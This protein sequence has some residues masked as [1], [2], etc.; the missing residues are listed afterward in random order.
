MASGPVLYG[1]L[2]MS[3]NAL[4]NNGSTTAG[5]EYSEVSLNSNHSRLG[6][7]GS[8]DLG[9]GMKVGYLI[10]WQVDMDGDG[11]NSGGA[12]LG[13]RNRAVTLSGD[14]GTMLAGR[15]DTPVKSVGRKVDLFP[16][17]L[18]DNRN[19]NSNGVLLDLRVPNVLAY[20][21]PNMNGFSSTIGYVF[22]AGTGFATP[23]APADNS[24]NS[25]FSINGIYNNGPIYVGVGYQDVYDANVVGSDNQK[26]IRVAGS[27]A[28]GDFKVLGSY[29]DVSNAGTT[30]GWDTDIWSLGASYKMGNNTIK[31]QLTERDEYDDAK[32]MPNSGDETGA[33]QWA[34]A[35]DHTMSKRTTV[36]VEYA[37]LS[38][39]DNSTS[40]S[41][42]AAGG[43]TA[44][45][46][47][48]A[49]GTKNRDTDGFG[50][51][52]IHKF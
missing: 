42:A 52:I 21:T 41:W 4:D 6:I 1:K 29:T 8:E 16:E 27:Y 39:D 45:V 5:N 32:D 26:T 22:D 47:T 3:I 43:N 49:A 34:I 46:G 40:R 14:W 50:V 20:V 33:K 9:N 51:G 23:G 7:K 28:F 24:D 2:Q 12:D 13:E 44:G 48:N 17:R 15:W 25:A 38:N 10:E 18:G 19:M 11:S 37:D 31:V 35:L 36:Y 30:D